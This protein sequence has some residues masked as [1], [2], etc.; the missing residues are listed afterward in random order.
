MFY[1]F[2]LI[3]LLVPGLTVPVWAELD[4]EVPGEQDTAATVIEA[5]EEELPPQTE[6]D[7][8]FLDILSTCTQTSWSD[9]CSDPDRPVAI[10][11]NH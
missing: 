8:A 10:G 2:L 7:I 9:W 4:Q 3:I 5:F 6:E 11:E 1:R